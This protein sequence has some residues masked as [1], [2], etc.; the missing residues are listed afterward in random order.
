V[1][2]AEREQI[3]AAAA[4]EAALEGLAEARHRLGND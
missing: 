1:T 4:L 2:V 3:L